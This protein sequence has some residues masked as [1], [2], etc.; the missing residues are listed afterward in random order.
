MAGDGPRGSAPAQGTPPPDPNDRWPGTPWLWASL[1]VD[2]LCLFAAAWLAA[3][4]ELAALLAYRRRQATAHREQI[5]ANCSTAVGALRLPI[6]R[7]RVD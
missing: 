4:P 2:L 7:Y 1:A 3:R 6:G 5:A